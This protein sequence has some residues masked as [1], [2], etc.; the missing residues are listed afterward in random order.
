MVH[1][2]LLYFFAPLLTA[3]VY[4]PRPSLVPLSLPVVRTVVPT[5]DHWTPESVRTK[6]SPS[7]LVAP[8][9]TSQLGAGDYISPRFGGRVDLLI[10]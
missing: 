9:P 6:S 2:I 3:T 8:P 7:C 4:L 5:T 1:R 10:F